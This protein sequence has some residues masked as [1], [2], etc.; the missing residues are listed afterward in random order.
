MAW[1]AP[2]TEISNELINNTMT[3]D[4]QKKNK[5]DSNEPDKFYDAI[6]SSGDEIYYDAFSTIEDIEKAF[7]KLEPKVETNYKEIGWLS[8]FSYDSYIDSIKNIVKNIFST[9]LSNLKI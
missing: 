3:Q 7:P 2:F 6:I 8:W 9:L 1:D 4:K 5:D